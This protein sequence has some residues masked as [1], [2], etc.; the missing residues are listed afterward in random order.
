MNYDELLRGL[1]AGE[2]FEYLLFYGHHQKKPGKVDLS[3]FSQW[4]HASFVVDGVHY[5]TAEHYMMAQKA[6]LFED[7]EAYE[8][9]LRSAD[10]REAK[11]L[12]R[13]VQNFV[14][15][16]WDEHCSEIVIEGNFHKF[17]QNPDLLTFILS[18]SPKIL[19]EASPSDRIWGIGLAKTEPNASNPT[20]WRG[21]NLLGFALVEARRRLQAQSL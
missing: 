6:K 3:C 12:G 10:P 14:P 5:L 11:Q 19:V 17:S 4:F 20:K 9:I 1:E 13:S 16:I 8:A 2:S 15:E 18:T 7:H 21:K